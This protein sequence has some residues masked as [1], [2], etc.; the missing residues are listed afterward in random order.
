MTDADAKQFGQDILALGEE[1]IGRDFEGLEPVEIEACEYCEFLPRCRT[2]WR[3]Q[4]RGE[5]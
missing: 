2:F 5:R 3:Q 1:I 4:V